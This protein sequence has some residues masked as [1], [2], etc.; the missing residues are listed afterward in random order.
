MNSLLNKDN[1]ADIY[2]LS[3]L[4]KGMLFHAIYDPESAVY[5]E[6]LTMQIEGSIDAASLERAWNLL[7][8]RNPILRTVFRWSNLNESVQVVLKRFPLKLHVADASETGKDAFLQRDRDTPFSLETGPLMRVS[9]LHIDGQNAL[10]VWSFHHILLDGWCLPL[11]MGDLLS[12]YEALRLGKPAPRHT[13]RPYREYIAWLQKQDTGAAI[14][15]WTE[16]LRDF[17]TRTPLPIAI[18]DG[19][20]VPRH[21]ETYL[22]PLNDGLS[23]KLRNTARF[24]RVTPNAICQA[25]WSI[26]LGRLGGETDIVYGTTLSGRPADLQGAEEMIGLFI[27]TLPMRVRLDTELTAGALARHLQAQI[28]QIQQHEL[29]DLSRIQALTSLKGQGSLF[30]TLF[31]YENYPLGSATS[32]SSGSLKLG[33]VSLSEMTNFPLTI[34]AAPSGN[35]LSL[36]IEYACDVY[37]ANAI[38][39]LTGYYCRT[40]EGIVNNPDCRV[41]DLPLLEPA[42]QHQLLLEWNETAE[43]Y[44]LHTS[45]HQMFE[46]QVEKK[47][48]AI[49]LVFEGQELTYND[50]NE[51][52]NQLAHHLRT[53]GVGPDVL[54]GICAERSLEMVIGLLGILKAGAA[55]VPLDP[56]YPK[57]RIAYMLADANPSILLTQQHLVDNLP[58]HC[59]PIFCLDA[60]WNTLT[61][62]SKKNPQSRIQP[63][64]LAYVIYTSGSTGKPKGVGIDQAGIV[65]RLLW[66]QQ[67]YGLSDTDRVLQKTPYS[68]DVSVWEFFW[69]LANGATLVLAKPAGHQD[70]HYLAQLITNQRITTLHFVPPMLDVFL[71]VLDSGYCHALRQVMC[72]GEVLPFELQQR[73]F[74]RFEQVELHNLYGPTEAS[75]DVTYWRCQ[76]ASALNFVPIGK[77]IANMRMYVLDTALNPVPVG[78]AGKLYIAGDGLSRGYLNRPGLTADKFTPNPFGPAGTRMYESGDLARYLADGNI[79]YLGRIDHQ[80]KIRGFRIELGEIEAALGSLPLVQENVV[81]AREDVTG[82]KR[83]VAYFMPQPG[84]AEADVSTDALRAQLSDILPEYMVPS[85][86]VLLDAFPLTPNGK[87]DRQVLPAPTH[88]RQKPGSI[89]VAPVT[90]TERKLALIWEQVLKV[91]RVGRYDNFFELGG[92]SLLAVTLV[93]RMRQQKLHVDVRSLF[94]APTLAMLAAECG[95]INRGVDV[96]PNRIPAQCE[97]IVPEMLP[98]LTLTQDEIN[99]I[100]SNVPGGARNIQDIYPL[101]PLQEGILFHHMMTTKGDAYLLPS[102]LAFDTRVRMEGF[103]DALQAVIRRHD[104]LRTAIVWEGL[105]EPVQVVWR[106]ALLQVEEV[107]LDPADGDVAE[108]LHTRFDPRQFRIDVR[109]APLMRVFVA[110]DAASGRW[111][112]MLLTHHMATDH[113]ALEIVVEE[114]QAH[115]LGYADR[116]PAPLPFRNFVA[117]ARLG[118]SREEHEKFF[119]SMLGDVDAPTAPFGLLDVQG[120]GSEIGEA[121]IDM[122]S[123]LAIRMR[124]CARMLGVSAASLCHLAWAQVLARISGRND[125]VFGT[126]LLGRMQGGEGAGRVLGMFINTLPMR[127]QIGSDSVEA[128]VRHTHQLLAE[129]LRHEHAPLVLAQRCS[130]V[131]VPVPLFSALLN[132]RH[133]AVDVLPEQALQAWEGM[134][135][136]SIEERTNYPVM[137]SIDD[138]GEGFRITAQVQ[139]PIEPGRICDF[140]HTAL[141]KLVDTL[142]SAPATEVSMLDVMPEAEK[143]RVLVEWNDTRADDRQDR[144]LAELFEEQADKT[145]QAIAVVYEDQELSY[146]ELNAKAN[147]L[148]HYLK[149]Q[150][151][152]ADVLVGICVERSLEMVIGLLGILKAGGAYV[153]LDPAYP[154]QRL[155]YMLADANIGIVLTQAR[156][157]KNLP[158]ETGQLLCLDADW[159][160]ISAMPSTAPRG[161]AVPDNLAYVIYTSGSTGQP[162]GV[163]SRHQSILRLV[164][165]SNY[166]NLSSSDTFLQAAPL[167]FDASTFEIWGAL[168]NGA[169]LILLPPG[170]LDLAVMEK[171]I[172]LQQVSVLWLTAGL[173]H[174]IIDQKPEMLRDVKQVLAGG[175]V[176]SPLHVK[177]LLK[178]RCKGHVINGYGPTENT[179]FTCCFV[180]SKEEDVGASVAIGAPISGTQV[181]VLDEYLQPVP[182]GVSGE[183]YTGGAGLARGYLGRPDM[184]AERFVPDPFGEGERL[185]RTGD[186]A[187]WR[188]DGQLEYLGRLDHQVKVRG[189]RIELG[190]IEAQLTRYPAVR[191]AVVLARGDEAGDKYL[192]AYYT[193]RLDRSEVGMAQDEAE[194]EEIRA[195]L[196]ANLP[197]YM[198]PTVY[199]KLDSLPLTPNGK[200]DRKALPASEH[201][202]EM[203]RGHYTSPRTSAE[204]QLVQIWEQVLKVEKVGVHD[205]FFDLGGHSLLAM[206]LVGNLSTALDR[207][208]PVR[209]VFD[210]PT[211]AALAVAISG[212][213]AKLPPIVRLPNSDYYPLS[214]AQ[215]RVWFLTQLEGAETAYNMPS[216]VRLRGPLNADLLAIVL[217]HLVDRHGVLR[218]TFITMNGEPMQWVADTLA[219]TLSRIYV[220]NESDPLATTRTHIAA[221]AA[222]AFDLETG[223]LFRA[224]LYQLGEN[225]HVLAIVMHHIISDGWSIELAVREVCE[226]YAALGDNEHKVRA[227]LPAPAV[228]Y[229]DYAQWQTKLISSGVLDSQRDYWRQRLAGELPSMQLPTDRPRPAVQ[230]FTGARLSISL[231]EQLQ[232]QLLQLCSQR[233]VTQFMLLLAAYKALL[234]RLSG[235]TDILVGTPIAGRHYPQVENLLGFFVNTLVLRTDLSD[236]PRFTELLERVRDTSLD[237]YANQD[238]PFDLLVDQLA[239][240]RDLSRQAVFSTTFTLH[241]L[242]FK[243]LPADTKASFI[244]EQVEFEYGSAKFDLGVAAAMTDGR[245]AIEF[246]YNSDLFDRDTIA[247]LAGYYQKLLEDIVLH[248]DTRVQ[249]LTLLDTDQRRQILHGFNEERMKWPVQEALGARI[250]QHVLRAPE[251]IAVVCGERQLSYAELNTQANRLAHRLRELG[252]VNEMP[253]AICLERS[254][255]QVIAI[256]AV[257]KAG[258]C[259]LPIEP[260]YPEERIAYMVGDAGA[261]I[262]IG[263]GTTAHALAAH[264]SQVICL[265]RDAKIIAACSDKTPASPPTPEQLAYIIYT[266]GSTG[267]PKGTMLTHAH[268]LRLFESCS[269]HYQFGANDVW[270]LFHSYCFDF[271]VWEIFGALL[272]GG[273]LVMV[274]RDISRSPQEFINLL[275]QQSV[276][277]LSQTPSA[278]IGLLDSSA[279]SNHW[280]WS[281]T[282]RYVV[283]GGEALEYAAL[284]SWFQHSA[285]SSTK[286]VN[287]YGITETTVH[288]TYRLVGPEDVYRAHGRLIGRA[289]SDLTVYILD[290]SGNPQPIGVKGELYVGGA[291]LARGYLGRQGLTAERFIP[292]PFG[293]DAGARLYRTGDLVSWRADGEIEYF[294]RLDQQ[295]KIRG[296]RIEPGEI[297]AALLKFGTISTC[298]VTTAIDRGHREHLVAYYCAHESF[299]TTALRSFLTRSLPEYMVPAL[300]IHLHELPLTANGKIDRSKLIY[301][302]GD[303]P[304]L[305]MPYVAPRTAAQLK[306]VDIWQG[307]LEVERVGIQD[308]FFDL[309]GESFSAYRLM[310][311]ISAEFGKELPLTVIFQAQTIEAMEQ[312]INDAIDADDDR[313]LVLLQPGAPDRI[314]FFCVHPA[315]GDILGF[316]EIASALGSDQP[317]YGLQSLG[318]F[319]DERYHVSLEEMA[320]HY[321]SEILTVQPQGPYQIGGHS[322]GAIVAFEI[323]RQLELLGHSVDLL[324]IIDGELNIESAMIDTLLLVSD[325]F[326][327]GITRA[328]LAPHPESEMMDVILRK[329]KKRFSRVLEIAY[330][331]DILPRGFRT[332]DAELFLNRIATNIDLATRFE[333]KPIQGKVHLFAATEYTENGKPVDIEVWRKHARGGLEVIEVPG[334]HISLMKSPHVTT[335]AACLRKE[336]NR[337]HD[338]TS[339]ANRFTVPHEVKTVNQFSKEVK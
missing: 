251:H 144:T 176:L 264:V 325:T 291:G 222:Q 138:L 203:L 300:Y 177:Q 336:L 287:M 91:E 246:E 15:F 219:I 306:L 329:A 88:S 231:G 93:E 252:T 223:P 277:V 169:R 7:V 263:S 166:I 151:V 173:F 50:L 217:Q 247:R 209:M 92:H 220:A 172:Q 75:V 31:V 61:R 13:R 134:Q 273:R 307:V 29:V 285:N 302:H 86:F 17:S 132:Y 117:Q 95:S 49:A 338:A 313:A 122:E 82:D 269:E 98:L 187:R 84:L 101:A 319:L 36:R 185:Y 83:L 205:N 230:S 9:L 175:D 201:S 77:P 237:A 26:V 85:A 218:T 181:Y 250:E 305:D 228:Q 225:D 114:I 316:H 232:S 212:A 70:A 6:Q 204:R 253:V 149:G 326:E 309:G 45:L 312:C 227:L 116:L 155:A 213:C 206:R 186:L 318:R 236:N 191:E 47:P 279:V 19:K 152:G 24:L 125:V 23:E 199:M 283:F 294:G 337:V 143:R 170:P 315:G 214:H 139:T 12:A 65:N 295:V 25:A 3:P 20:S 137:L 245:L 89:H 215:R 240:E 38:A 97:A 21:V 196:S 304:D 10:L 131:P 163:M 16:Q 292:D 162:K 190:E 112:L 224:S 156:L 56:A 8:E 154:Q 174:S 311:R 94:A 322:M 63:H 243:A 44:A 105:S 130:A 68:F 281:E 274:P 87:I 102:L 192:V 147:Q 271:S 126:V 188:A 242:V 327:L 35:N 314:P 286:L 76:P 52:A 145:P 28:M 140:M 229:V 234:S 282:L 48:D 339:S 106:D 255:D 160:E 265:E 210:Y 266:S 4:Q 146:G 148:A 328:E 51:K 256:L 43:D 58:V 129:L 180:M 81:V 270:S 72:S 330:D 194:V 120:D 183:L 113:T 208:I 159:F 171:L 164:C 11:L 59:V 123:G 207:N 32:V 324:A 55:Y 1:I 62:Q 280:G 34:I 323:T 39:R 109:Q 248:P 249:D 288:V 168:L 141:E 99:G 73:F 178:S 40:L 69:P 71:N 293:K 195:H 317:F 2:P 127:I 241:N 239:A 66:M 193:L 161:N 290:G 331:L 189:F 90:E 64:N 272:Y 60:D 37:N 238:Y 308:N 301:T 96:P 262:G 158:A 182:A 216:A 80:V 110:Q 153:P 111:L 165:N 244:T 46:A 167:A 202:C 119:R 54:V 74:R 321:V 30:D 200:L 124:E 42:E 118:I 128:S 78:V 289:L 259:Y 298:F 267:R 257:L 260:G 299:T 310:A 142:Q 14:D 67:M 233:Q 115:L 197:D 100:S 79:E 221:F 303:R 103:I 332:R 179:T 235:Q 57:E 41:W 27:N 104:I 320:S 33:E 198:V 53:A 5:L 18:R 334:N 278:F 150:G 254:V 261:S 258:G 133:S 296:H 121:C 297:E 284:A 275:Q 184:T 333:P 211:V 268:V 335:L 136:L 276:T 22:F 135:M 226:L 107:S 157:T 108:Q